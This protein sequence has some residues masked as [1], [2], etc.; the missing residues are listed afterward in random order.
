MF[1]YQEFLRPRDY[2]DHRQG[3]GHPAVSLVKTP[4]GAQASNHTGRD[5]FVSDR[6]SVAN[7]TSINRGCSLTRLESPH[8]FINARGE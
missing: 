4:P 3:Y 6:G 1:A 7:A 2:L 5:Y 8:G